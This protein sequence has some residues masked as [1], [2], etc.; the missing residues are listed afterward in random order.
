MSLGD[1]DSNEADFARLKEFFDTQRASGLTWEEVASS[2]GVSL[3]QITRARRRMCYVDNCASTR[4][5]CILT[6]DVSI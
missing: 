1:F 3:S 6:A 4:D 5:P 2:V